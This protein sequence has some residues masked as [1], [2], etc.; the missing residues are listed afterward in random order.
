MLEKNNIILYT[1]VL[2][3]AS[4]LT[5]FF[6]EMSH[7]VSYELLGYDA[8]FTLNTAN[9][10]DSE[11]VLSKT[12]KIITSGSGPLFTILQALFVFFCIKEKK[13][14]IS[15]SLSFPSFCNAIRCRGSKYL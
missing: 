12:Q 5:F 4:F 13:E 15:L 1:S 7:W 9:L 14:F 6:H 11:I 8:G 10:K 2:A 3:L